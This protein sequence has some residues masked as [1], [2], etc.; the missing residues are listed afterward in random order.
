MYTVN[1]VP[2]V[3]QFLLTCAG[4]SAEPL[5]RGALVEIAKLPR[6]TKDLR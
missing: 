1:N 3:T 2:M 5:G 4:I 6:H